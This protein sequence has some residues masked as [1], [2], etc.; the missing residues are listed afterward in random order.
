MGVHDLGAFVLKC[1]LEQ[2][3]IRNTA[4]PDRH[5]G[6]WRARVTRACTGVRPSAHGYV[7]ELDQPTEVAVLEGEEWREVAVEK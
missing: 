3:L 2:R 6:V 1:V 4:E 5:F 7:F